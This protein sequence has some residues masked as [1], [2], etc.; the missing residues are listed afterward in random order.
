MKASLALTALGTALLAAC[1]QQAQPP[2]TQAQATGTPGLYLIVYKDQSIP[3]KPMAAAP[4]GKIVQAIP[5]IGV[6]SAF[7]TPGQ[8]L[9][10]RA[11]PNV[12]GVAAQT[13][14]V[15]PEAAALPIEVVQP[16]GA[17]TL[18]PDAVPIGPTSQDTYWKN[19][20]NVRR[21]GAPAAWKRV[22]PE[23][24]AKVTVAVIGGG[25]MDDHP[26]LAGAVAY[27]KGTSIC[28]EEGG[29]NH[30]TAYPY[31]RRF[32]DLTRGSD[33]Y[34]CGMASGVVMDAGGTMMAGMIAGRFG[35]GAMVGV[36]PFV[37]LAACKVYDRMFTGTY[38]ISGWFDASVLAAIADAA[39]HGFPIIALNVWRI[40]AQGD[41]MILAWQR[42]IKF[43]TAR[44]SLIVAV[45]ASLGPSSWTP[46][47]QAE[48]LAVA[49]TSTTQIL[50]G[51]ENVAAPGSDML[52]SYYPSGARVDI[53]APGGGNP[54]A[55]GS[56]WDYY[57]IAPAPPFFG[58]PAY[59]SGAADEYAVDHAAGVAALVKAKYPNLTPALLRFWLQATAERIGPRDQFGA[60]MVN[61]QRATMF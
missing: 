17:S 46:G 37:K 57:I 27:A 14:H 13:M 2:T 20:W 10:L 4:G 1:G 11:A 30:S 50:F 53:A 3:V 40:H 31:Y 5:Q 22:S 45:A 61:A 44:G 33:P 25:V 6:A 56:W 43:A 7:L 49:R 55:G 39:E 23:K 16:S 54:P 60:G 47:Q 35:G 24:Q 58:G 42:A 21:V 36:A 26:D 18:A 12:A 9:A 28:P 8:A 34:V 15:V 29:P 32:V 59:A 48:T 38:I 52:A 19:Q 51:P 41:P